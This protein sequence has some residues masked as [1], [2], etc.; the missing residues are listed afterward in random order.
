MTYVGSLVFSPRGTRT[1]IDGVEAIEVRI[2]NLRLAD[3]RVE[4]NFVPSNPGQAHLYDVLMN[5]PRRFD[6]EV[7]LPEVAGASLMFY[8][9]NAYDWA[10]SLPPND[11]ASLWFHFTWTRA[12]IHYPTPGRYHNVE[13]GPEI[14]T[15]RKERENRWND[16]RIAYFEMLYKIYN[17][18]GTALDAFLRWQNEEAEKENRIRDLIRRVFAEQR[19]KDAPALRVTRR[20]GGGFTEVPLDDW[21]T[22]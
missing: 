11:V 9:V 22:T 15:I 6:M 20:A 18:Q 14:A 8:G 1:F 17:G 16:T 19:V 21:H 7:E 5:G 10:V 12:E 4:M 2:V 3:N 13:D